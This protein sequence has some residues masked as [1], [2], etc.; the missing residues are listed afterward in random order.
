VN[1]GLDIVI[2]PSPDLQSMQLTVRTWP[3][4]TPGYSYSYS[5]PT[6]QGFALSFL[7]VPPQQTAGVYLNPMVLTPNQ[8]VAP[9]NNS[10]GF[11]ARFNGPVAS[12]GNRSQIQ[13]H[14]DQGHLGDNSFTFKLGYP[15][16]VSTGGTG[17]CTNGVGT[18]FA[19]GTFTRCVT[20]GC[21]GGM[22]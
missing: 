17:T 12:F 3:Q 22:F 7:G 5:F 10:A 4:Y 14:V 18:W 11:E 2:I 15:N 8:P 16:C 1:G 19:Q 13:V 21:S 6:L 20:P 9:I